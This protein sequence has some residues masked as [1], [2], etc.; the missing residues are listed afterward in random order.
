MPLVRKSGTTAAEFYCIA[1]KNSR[2]TSGNP[3]VVT[4][5]LNRKRFM[6]LNAGPQFKF[7]EAISL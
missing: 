2:I 5:E 4:F 1:F 6:G 7:N 3:M